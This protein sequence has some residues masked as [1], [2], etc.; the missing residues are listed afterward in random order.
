MAE[1]AKK[2]NHRDNYFLHGV[3]RA[4][5]LVPRREYRIP[6]RGD[7]SQDARAMQ[8]DF[9]KVARDMGYAVRKYGAG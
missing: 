1:S 7:F 3:S 5:V 8:G 9:V 4:L 2:I 6:Q